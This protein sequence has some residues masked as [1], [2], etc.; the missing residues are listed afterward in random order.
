[1]LFDTKRVNHSDTPI[2]GEGKT[3]PSFTPGQRGDGP[4]PETFVE[5]RGPSNVGLR[6]SI[7]M[8]REVPAYREK[9]ESAIKA[10]AIPKKHVR[11]VRD[12]FTGLG[13]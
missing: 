6:S 8:I 10:N 4:G 13:K 1:M 3:S 2:A 5:V 11:R 9:A 7:P 12:Y